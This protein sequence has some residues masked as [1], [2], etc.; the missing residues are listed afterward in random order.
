M[1]THGAPRNKNLF[2]NVCAFQDRIGIWKCWFL[3]RRE[4]RSTRRKTSPQKSREPTTNS[5]HI[6]RRVRESNPG[7][8]GGRRAL[9]P[10]CHPCSTN[11]GRH[12]IPVLT[13]Q[14]LWM[15]HSVQL[16]LVSSS[17]T[18]ICRS[19]SD[20]N[21]TFLHCLCFFLVCYNLFAVLWLNKLLFCHFISLLRNVSSSNKSG[22]WRYW[23]RLCV[24]DL[25]LRDFT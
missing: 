17:C 18:S 21:F 13:I 23:K 11:S 20:L 8:I 12:L 3:R 6:W 19:S 14:K 22:A 5:S 9:S 25:N 2:R 10:L 15:S 1:F 24:G 7:D 4:N 16:S